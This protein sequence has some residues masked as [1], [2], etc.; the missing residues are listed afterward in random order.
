MPYLRLVPPAEADGAA[1]AMY[2]RQ[3]N[4]NG[5]VPNHAKAFSLHPE[6]NEAWVA[7]IGAIRKNM[8]V[9]RY[10]LVTLAAARALNSS[11]CMLA[12]GSILADKVFDAGTVQAIA[13]DADGTPLDAAERAMM[14]YAEKIAR[15]ADQVTAEDIDALRACGFN[16]TEI[17]DIAATACARCFFSKLLDAVGMQAD[18]KFLSLDA[19][20]RAA[21]TVGRPVATEPAEHVPLA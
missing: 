8:S 15:H 18:T 11:Y 6:V 4:A 12:H 3:E 7:M 20:L 2:Q 1:R 17:F 10:E 21:L 14:G 5:F 19:D 16:D 9:R 13:V